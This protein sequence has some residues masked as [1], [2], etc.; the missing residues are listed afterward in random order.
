MHS[1]MEVLFS[2]CPVS[3]AAPCKC[4]TLQAILLL[5][6]AGKGTMEVCDVSVPRCSEPEAAALLALA[7]QFKPHVW[8][9]VHSGM[10]ALFMP[11]DHLA[12]IPKGKTAEATLEVCGHTIFLQAIF[13]KATECCVQQHVAISSPV[14]VQDC[15]LGFSCGTGLRIAVSMAVKSPRGP[16][17]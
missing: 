1:G 14:F 10:E 6:Y 3:I 5:L 2:V 12:T 8:M 16:A 4:H 15:T 11:Y 17:I 7:T 13:C 9:N